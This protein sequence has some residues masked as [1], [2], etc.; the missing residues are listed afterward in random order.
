MYELGNPKTLACQVCMTVEQSNTRFIEHD[1]IASGFCSK[2][3]FSTDSTKLAISPTIPNASIV[4]NIHRSEWRFSAFFLPN[5]HQL[6][7]V[8]YLAYRRQRQSSPHILQ[9]SIITKRNNGRIL[10]N[11]IRSTK[12]ST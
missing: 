11:I 5:G 3:T 10:N 7:I 9:R 2:C 6:N 1:S 4:P 8:T 12:V